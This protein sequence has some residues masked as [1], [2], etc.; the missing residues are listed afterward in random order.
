[1]RRSRT[2]ELSLQGRT[3]L[4]SGSRLR[5]NPASCLFRLA[6]RFGTTEDAGRFGLELGL[7]PWKTKQAMELAT[8]EWVSWFNHHRLMETL[9]YVPPVEFE[10]NT[11]FNVLITP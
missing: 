1:M 2:L 7:R 9:G 6:D 4:A 5:A 8:L 11:I 3:D 10:A